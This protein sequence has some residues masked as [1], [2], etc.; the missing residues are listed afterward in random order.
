MSS[1]GGVMMLGRQ[2]SKSDS[3]CDLRC[4]RCEAYW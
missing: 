2:S 1:G 3:I 4:V